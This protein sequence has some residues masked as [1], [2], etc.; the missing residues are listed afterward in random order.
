MSTYLSPSYAHG[1]S[2]DNHV[3]I[4]DGD[5]RF[6]SDDAGLRKMIDESAANIAHLEELV[7]QLEAK[8][9]ESAVQRS[10]EQKESVPSAIRQMAA[11]VVSTR[12]GR[13]RIKGQSIPGDEHRRMERVVESIGAKVLFDG[14]VAFV[15]VRSTEQ[16]HVAVAFLEHRRKTPRD[17]GVVVLPNYA[18]VR[19]SPD[20]TKRLAKHGISVV[21]GSDADADI[22]A[23]R[24]FN[25]SHERSVRAQANMNAFMNKE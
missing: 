16:F 18:R 6:A 5:V 9:K 15:P 10:K 22:S 17:M 23:M 13:H 25:A 7:R 1:D 11:G 8:R 14:S 3:E 21:V 20:V 4:G 2:A 12:S 19:F 24:Y